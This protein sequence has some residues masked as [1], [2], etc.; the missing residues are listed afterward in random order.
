MSRSTRDAVPLGTSDAFERAEPRQTNVPNLS[1]PAVLK[2]CG[3]SVCSREC[4]LL[5]W[6]QAR[7]GTGRGTMPSSL[8]GKNKIKT[9]QRGRAVLRQQM[10]A[11]T[12]PGTHTHRE[13][14][15]ESEAKQSIERSEVEFPDYAQ[16]NLSRKTTNTNCV[17]T[18]LFQT[19]GTGIGAPA[20]SHRAWF[21]SVRCLKTPTL[22]AL[23]SLS[24]DAAIPSSSVKAT[25]T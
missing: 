11:L 22:G 4:F 25:Y 16:L 15:R 7:Q 10:S 13:R 17:F 5:S 6:Y 23:A 18:W 24:F 20:P 3:L 12:H 21:Q 9:K 8:Q 1:L 14:E 2:S 19:L